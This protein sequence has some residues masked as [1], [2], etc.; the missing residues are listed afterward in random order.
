MLG[1]NMILMAAWG[2][3]CGRRGVNHVEEP[4]KGADAFIAAM[5]TMV[6]A[7]REAATVTTR[8]IDHSGER[9]GNHNRGRNREHGGDGNENEDIGNHDNPMTLKTFMKVNSPKFKGTLIA[10]EAENWLYVIE[11]SLRAQHVPEKQHVKFATYMLEGE[12][13]HWWHGVQCLL[14]Q[15][16]EDIDW[17]TLRRNFTKNI[18]LDLFVL[19]KKWN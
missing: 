16:V 19:L 2:R 14:R 13:K 8:A 1:V 9:N 18:F 5:N 3:G 4:M 10:T 11:K 17:D 12:V 7:V 6:E 15:E